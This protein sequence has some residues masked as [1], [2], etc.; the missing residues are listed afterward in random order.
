MHVHGA[1]D[2]KELRMYIVLN[3]NFDSL[4]IWHVLQKSWIPLWRRYHLKVEVCRLSLKNPCPSKLSSKFHVCHF[5]SSYVEQAEVPNRSCGIWLFQPSINDI[6]YM[7]ISL[8]NVDGIWMNSYLYFSIDTFYSLKPVFLDFLKLSFQSHGDYFNGIIC[9]HDVYKMI[10]CSPKNTD[11]VQ[12]KSRPPEVCIPID[13]AFSFPWSL[14]HHCV[15][16]TPT[17]ACGRCNW[18]VLPPSGYPSCP[19]HSPLIPKHHKGHW[20]V[21]STSASHW[22]LVLDY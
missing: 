12:H 16:S 8:Y 14:L 7:A 21:R 9:P 13:L 6:L 2:L 3:L 11:S 4:Q 19:Y 5:F 22:L 17:R 10:V 15:I 18:R 1:E 20:R